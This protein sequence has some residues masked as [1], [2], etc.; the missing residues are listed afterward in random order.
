MKLRR[1]NENK[2]YNF[3]Y[4]YVYQCF[5]DLIESDKC[6]IERKKFSTMEYAKLTF[7]MNVPVS[8]KKIFG[9]QLPIS[10]EGFN[11]YVEQQQKQIELLRNISIALD[12]LCIE[13]PD[14]YFEIFESDRY[15]SLK[16]IIEIYPAKNDL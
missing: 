10:D 13:Y 6:E 15:R 3:N 8:T 16:Y 4:Q 5:A 9:Q 12:R 14:Y 1:F 7:D 11:E 2:E